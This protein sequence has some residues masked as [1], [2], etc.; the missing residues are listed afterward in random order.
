MRYSALRMTMQKETKA[1]LWPCKALGLPQQFLTI[2]V[3]LSCV[4]QFVGHE[5]PLHYCRQVSC[6]RQ[7]DVSN[8][9]PRAKKTPFMERKLRALQV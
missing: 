3:S 6:E 7:P 2:D 8:Y 9:I 4:V 1:K 5:Q